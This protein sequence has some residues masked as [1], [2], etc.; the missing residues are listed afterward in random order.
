MCIPLAG[1]LPSCRRGPEL[2]IHRRS[3]SSSSFYMHVDEGE[4]GGDTSVTCRFGPSVGRRWNMDGGRRGL[5]VREREVYSGEG[6]HAIKG[7]RTFLSLM[8]PCD[9]GTAVVRRVA[10]ANG[11]RQF[12]WTQFRWVFF[13]ALSPHVQSSQ[14][15]RL[16]VHI[17]LV[18]NFGQMF[19]SLPFFS[20]EA[21]A[22]VY[23]GGGGG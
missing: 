4:E 8:C 15:S 19:S 1:L 14:R 18:S 12:D 11:A 10:N 7:G 13:A 2:S 5:F 20:R 23:N 3:C 6:V 16:S 21:L 9:V 22:A 17:C